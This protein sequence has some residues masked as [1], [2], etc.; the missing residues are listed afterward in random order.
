MLDGI[1]LEK[2]GIPA[3]SIITEPFRPT[4]K[5]MAT[6][7][8]VPEYRFLE[9]RHP[10]SNLTEAQLDARADA[11]IDQVLWLLKTGQAPE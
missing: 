9:M 2:A 6:N 4:G 11:I 1:L 5:E 7:W 8:G 10:I 3:V